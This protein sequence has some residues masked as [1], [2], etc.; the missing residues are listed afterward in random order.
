VAYDTA[1][2]LLAL[3][4]LVAA[5]SGVQEAGIGI[6]E[7]PSVQRRV[8]LTILESPTSMSR[9]NVRRRD[10]AYLLLWATALGGDERQAELDLAAYKDDVHDRFEIAISSNPGAGP[11]LP[12]DSVLRDDVASTPEYLQ[13]AGLEVR[14]YPMVAV[15]PMERELA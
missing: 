6:P 8:S 9:F 14:Q 5:C 13:Y 11:T 2:H 10:Q 3:E 7:S 4:T 12:A 1:A 15:I